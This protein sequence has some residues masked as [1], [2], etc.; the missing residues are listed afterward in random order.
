[1][2]HHIRSLITYVL[3]NFP[4]IVG[5]IL[6]FVAA[7]QCQGIDF[8]ALNR[9][10]IYEYEGSVNVIAQAPWDQIH[11]KLTQT[12]GW[13]IRGTVKLQRLDDTTLAASVSHISSK[14]ISSLQ[15]LLPIECDGCDVHCIA[16]EIPTLEIIII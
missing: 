2:M 6:V 12:V 4:C 7:C 9:E 16:H 5:A 8:V 13:K 10:I 3:Q 11:L 1:M 15:R 14:Q